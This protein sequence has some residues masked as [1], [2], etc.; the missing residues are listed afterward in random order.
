MLIVQSPLRIS[1][2]GG[3]TDFAEYYREEEGCVL[4]TAID[5]YVFVLA[6]RRFDKTIRVRHDM[7]ELVER[8]SSL[9]HGLIREALQLVGID[10]QVEID[11]MGSIT[12][13]GSGLGS[14]SALIVGLLN[15][16]YSLT[17]NPQPFENLARQ[18][19]HIEIDHLGQPIGKQ[20]QYISTYG[21]LKFIRFLADESV[22]VERLEMPWVE[23]QRLNA[24]LMLFNTN[25][26][27][28]AETILTEQKANIV[29][30]MHVLRNIKSLAIEGRHLLEQGDFDD[31]GYLLH[32]GWL[33]KKQMAAKISNSHIDR[34]YENA[35]QAGALGG[36]ITG[37][38][39]G[40]F[41]LLYC[42]QD[43]QVQVRRALAPL[44]QLPINF[45][46]DGTKVIFDCQKD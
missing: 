5:K 7:I 28:K 46:R 44:S 38:G 27:R 15:A 9:K 21:G 8:A 25:M 34:F 42:T 2:L 29:N 43:R 1:F 24:N 6:K 45:E 30:R 17:G 39:G 19:C 12:S 40:G 33:L 3:G 37:A 14:S 32:E 13:D 18:A 36:K 4:S 41:L 11:L 10:Q 35:I 31:F 22:I 20:D 26:V 16:L 23:Q